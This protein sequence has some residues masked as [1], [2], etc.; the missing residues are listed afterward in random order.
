MGL[1][2]LTLYVKRSYTS[3]EVF[4]WI[5]RR[6]YAREWTLGSNI[7]FILE[8][9]IIKTMGKYSFC[10]RDI[11]GL[12][13]TILLLKKLF[14]GSAVMCRRLTLT[15]HLT[16]FLEDSWRG[17]TFHSRIYFRRLASV[18]SY[19]VQTPK[20]INSF[21][22]VQQQTLKNN[23]YSMWPAFDST[24]SIVSVYPVSCTLR[25]IVTFILCLVERGKSIIGRNGIELLRIRVLTAIARTKKYCVWCMRN[26]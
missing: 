10:V 5:S 19:W 26:S 22:R 21:A 1:S 16:K 15:A 4:I 8:T 9:S 3:M 25:V 7:V 6:R 17:N 23:R 14:V 20:T 18:T 13:C 11:L 12:H 24:S 2:W